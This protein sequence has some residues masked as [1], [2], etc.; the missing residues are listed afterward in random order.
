[1]RNLFPTSIRLSG[2]ALKAAAALV[3][4]NLLFVPVLLVRAAPGMTGCTE[5]AEL[6]A[7]CADLE[8]DCERLTEALD[9]EYLLLRRVEL[10]LLPGLGLDWLSIRCFSFWSDVGRIHYETSLEGTS[11]TIWVSRLLACNLTTL[12]RECIN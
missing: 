6:Q 4:L 5:C 12:E 9:T 11:E 1:M 3:A 8:A 10:Q 7:R 2:F